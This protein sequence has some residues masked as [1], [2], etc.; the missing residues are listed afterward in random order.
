MKDIDGI[1]AP[2]GRVGARSS[3]RLSL[4][5]QLVVTLV[6]AMGLL[7]ALLTGFGLYGAQRKAIEVSDAQLLQAGQVLLTL[8]THELQEEYPNPVHTVAEITPTLF[9]HN[10]QSRVEP[11]VF[12]ARG[13]A[14]RLLYQSAEAIPLLSELMADRPKGFADIVVDDETW[15]VVVVQNPEADL[16]VAVAQR[17]RFQRELAGELALYFIGPLLLALPLL[18]LIISIAIDRGLVPLKRLA[19]KVS[20]RSV[21][22]PT[23]LTDREVP[24]EA[25][26]LTNALDDL[27]RRLRQSRE[28]EQRFVADA[29]HE[30]RT[31]LAGLKT[32]AQVALAAAND[33]QRTVALNSLGQGV[34]QATRL[35]GQLLTLARLDPDTREKDAEAIDL[36]AVATEVAADLAP[37]AV[38]VGIDLVLD[39]GQPCAV[40]ADRTLLAVLTRNLV[41]NAIQYSGKES[42]KRVTIRLECDTAGTRLSV[43]DQGPGI[44]SQ[45][46]ERV[47]DRFYRSSGNHTPGSGLGLSIVKR[48]ADRCGAGV[49]L[50]NHPEGG[51]LVAVSFPPG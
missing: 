6:G 10:E 47:F 36:L 44:R 27:L 39:A 2:A 7:W 28:R 26:P 31:P 18:G 17:A 25:L 19:V 45:D 34:D 43:R 38:A 5:R 9:P 46:L 20:S 21:N 30:L 35:V 8:L 24:R 32:Q 40:R 12:V 42:G 48:V 22:D 13:E 23:S 29:A 41:E 15:R 51:L 14:G 11:P 49:V 4:R 50:N 37:R 3:R 1:G 16:W 33:A